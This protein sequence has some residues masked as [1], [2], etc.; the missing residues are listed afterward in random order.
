MAVPRDAHDSITRKA[1]EIVRRFGPESRRSKPEQAEDAIL[2]FLS[3]GE[4]APRAEVVAHL[5]DSPVMRD[6]LE[7]YWGL[8]TG[9]WCVRS[10]RV[11]T[12]QSG[13]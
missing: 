7:A 13:P 10:L 11:E 1:G 2:E 5:A 9:P 12:D 3:D 6:T 8:A 4:F